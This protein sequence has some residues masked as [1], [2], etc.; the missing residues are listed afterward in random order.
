ML[1]TLE[2]VYR[3]IQLLYGVEVVAVLMQVLGLSVQLFGHVEFEHDSFTIQIIGQSSHDS[4][5]IHLI[6]LRDILAHPVLSRLHVAKILFTAR[7]VAYLNLSAE[8]GATPLIW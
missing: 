6:G 4:M 1:L 8:A 5:A 7:D 3:I 2:R